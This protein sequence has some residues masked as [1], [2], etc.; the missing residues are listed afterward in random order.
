MELLGVQNLSR[1]V[2]TI[3]SIAGGC[4]L[5][6]AADGGRLADA[7]TAAGFEA[8]VIGSLWEGKAKELHNGGEVRYLEPYRGIH[9]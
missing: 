7:L 4:V 9:F 6:A 5:M 3:V 8:A 2:V 1:V